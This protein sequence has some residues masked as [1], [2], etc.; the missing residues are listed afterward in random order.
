MPMAIVV[1]FYLAVLVFYIITAWK[2]FEKAGQPG[3][4]IFVPIYNYLVFL[5]IGGK[6]WW[7]IFF[8]LTGPFF[9]IWHIWAINMFVKSFGKDEGFTVGVVFLGGIFWP[10]L[11]FSDARYIGPYGDPEAFRAAQNPQFDFDNPT[12]AV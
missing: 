6:P 5:K 2:L 7:W 9:L 11:A 4:A 10:I 8:I 12:P 1:I 3:W